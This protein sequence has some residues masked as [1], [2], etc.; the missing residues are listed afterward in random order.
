M[1]VAAL[2]LRSA[3]RLCLTVAVFTEERG[4]TSSRRGTGLNEGIKIIRQP[5]GKSL[6]ALRGGK[7]VLTTSAATRQHNVDV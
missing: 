6:S 4:Y 1:E 3:E 2:P 7:A 5:K